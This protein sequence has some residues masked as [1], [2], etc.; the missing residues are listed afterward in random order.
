MA[1][2]LRI[3][4]GISPERHYTIKRPGMKRQIF[5]SRRIPHVHTC[6]LK[7]T[8]GNP[9]PAESGRLLAALR[10]GARTRFTLPAPTGCDPP[11]N[12][13]PDGCR[14]AIRLAHAAGAKVYVA[15][16]VLPL[17]REI[18]KLPAYLEL[19]GR[20]SGR[21]LIVADLGRVVFDEAVCSRCAVHISTQT[22]VVNYEA[23]RMH[24][25]GASR[26][27]LARSCLWPRRSSLASRRGW[28]W[29]A[30]FTGDV[31][32]GVRP[33]PALQRTDG[34][35]RQPRRLRPAPVGGNTVSLRRNAPARSTKSGKERAAPI[36]LTRT[37]CA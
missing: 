3:P 23:A 22:G 20:R 15:C 7:K 16:N 12:F 1:A 2:Q 6:C 33:L 18:D 28:R 30:S 32:V 34:T 19:V 26:V 29:S 24:E 37:I 31:H 27:V 11:V 21:A 13:T 4:V 17:Q 10:Y 9:C 5:F 36:F 14:D 35:G 8:S 25:L